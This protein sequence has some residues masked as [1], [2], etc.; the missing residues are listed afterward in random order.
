[1]GIIADWTVDYRTKT[2][3]IELKSVS[4]NSI[5]NNLITYIKRFEVLFNLDQDIPRYRTYR[6]I[7]NNSNKTVVNRA[8]EILI[9]WMYE[10]IVYSRRY[11]LKSLL[12]SCETFKNSEDFKKHIDQFFAINDESALLGIVAEKPLEHD[13]WFTIF[14]TK[15]ERAGSTERLAGIKAVLNRL[16][17][18]NR[19]NIGLNLISGLIMLI[20]GDFHA[21]DGRDRMSQALADMKIHIPDITPIFVKMFESMKPYAFDPSQNELLGEILI[22]HYPEQAELIYEN[23]QDTSSLTLLLKSAASRIRSIGGS[24]EW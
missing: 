18:S 11:A 9:S 23:L 3:K 22:E 4:D 1:M 14:D 7:W 24:V 12:D 8:L 5:F 17:E 2:I 15:S 21:V 6:D 19:Y 16:F 13:H 10:N 20:L